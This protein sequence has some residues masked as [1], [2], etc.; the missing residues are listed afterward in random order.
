LRGC[1]GCTLACSGQARHWRSVCK[2]HRFSCH[3]LY[4]AEVVTCREISAMC[5]SGNVGVC[6]LRRAD[7]VIWLPGGISFTPGRTGWTLSGVRRPPWS[8]RLWR[9]RH[10][11][12]LPEAAG[13]AGLPDHA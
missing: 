3:A 1:L 8:E 7:M 12:S 5:G 13:F 9:V 2:S 6:Q 11:S 4:S 10:R